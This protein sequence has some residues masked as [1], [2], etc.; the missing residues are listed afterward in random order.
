MR[1]SQKVSTDAI[2]REKERE[3]TASLRAPCVK[4]EDG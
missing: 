2:W 4:P 3:R 1:L